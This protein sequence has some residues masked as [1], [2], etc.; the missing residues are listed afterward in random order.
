MSTLQSQTSHQAGTNPAFPPVDID[1][2]ALGGW[3]RTEDCVLVD[4]RE[5]FEHA[6]ERIEHAVSIPLSTL[7]PNALRERF[8]DK[9][10]VF[11]CAGGKR[12]AQACERFS[13]VSG[14]PTC[15]LAGGIEAWKQALM[16]TLKPAK[17]SLPVM[18]QVQI[19]AGAMVLLGVVLGLAVSVWFLALSGFVGAGLMFAGTTG[20]CGMAKLLAKMPWN[21]TGKPASCTVKP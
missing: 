21:T 17:A 12:S 1:P 2:A 7:D 4:V 16:P 19:V 13:E 9:Q 6:A 8:P 10:L 3:M 20:W 14:Q 18:R 5:P 15:H 11:H